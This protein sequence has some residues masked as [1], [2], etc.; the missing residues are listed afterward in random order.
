M[1]GRSTGAVSARLVPCGSTDRAEAFCPALPIGDV[2][3]ERLGFVGGC[4]SPTPRIRVRI[5]AIDA[6]TSDTFIAKWQGSELKERSAAQ[7]HFIDLCRLLGAL[8]SVV[9]GRLA[10]LRVRHE[11]EERFVPCATEIDHELKRA[12][13]RGDQLKS[14]FPGP[15]EEAREIVRAQPDEL[16]EKL[17]TSRPELDDPATWQTVG[18]CSQ[19]FR[20]GEPELAP[21]RE[22][23]GRGEI[24][25]KQSR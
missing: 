4:D 10:T 6:M 14:Q 23:S 16:T 2:V 11:G 9:L 13:E 15:L 25:S 7:E 3:D 18:T 8:R 1:I 24:Q 12:N 22:A 21:L 20:L 17:R 5:P 19:L